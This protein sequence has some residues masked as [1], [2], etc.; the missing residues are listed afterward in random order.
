[1]KET[2]K[3]GSKP[4]DQWTTYAAT[5]SNITEENST[6]VY[7]CQELKHFCEVVN[8][9]SSKYEDYRSRVSDCIKSRVSWSG[10]E[11]MRDIIF[12]LSIHDW[13]KALE[14]DNMAA[15]NWLV[16]MFA[17]PLQGAQAN[18][19]EIVKEFREM[20]SY[21]TQYIALAVLDYHSV[22]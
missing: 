21:A 9:Y 20:I 22:W 13:E 3:L 4:L 19:E 11:L 15:I 8:L 16:E 1:M 2:D 6:K 18:T 17:V 12:M 10:L 14:E 7:Q 5:L